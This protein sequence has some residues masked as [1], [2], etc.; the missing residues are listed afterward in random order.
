MPRLRR[1][2]ESRE[3]IVAPRSD[4]VLPE[5]IH[6]CFPASAALTEARHAAGRALDEAM[7]TELA[8]LKMERAVFVTQVAKAAPGPEGRDAVQ[9]RRDMEAHFAG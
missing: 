8:P 1:S 9:V 5:R 2:A 6:H 7:T 3:K 4:V